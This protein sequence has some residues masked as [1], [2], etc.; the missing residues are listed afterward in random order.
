[1]GVLGGFAGGRMARDLARL[2]DRRRREAVLDGLGRLFGDRAERPIEVYEKNWADDQW[3]RGCYNALAATGALTS[4]GPALREPVGRIH[5]AGS[6]TGIHANGSMGGAVD[7]GERTAREVLDA[8]ELEG[9]GTRRFAS[10]AAT[11]PV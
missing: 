9:S 10:D 7:S 6:E 8:L 3:T 4:F 1:M 5:W 11:A 2:P